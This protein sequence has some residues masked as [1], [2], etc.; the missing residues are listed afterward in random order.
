MVSAVPLR[1]Q[2]YESGVAQLYS[3]GNM[4]AKPKSRYY[5]RFA[6]ITA[7][8]LTAF[9]LLVDFASRFSDLF[10]DIYRF[11]V[12]IP[13]VATWI[14]EAEVYTRHPYPEG[15]TMETMLASV[16][17]VFLFMQWFLVGLAI[18]VVSGFFRLRSQ[19]VAT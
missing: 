10:G 4:N 17:W 16:L 9:T 12:T 7:V 14:L 8:V 5:F 1:G 6:L 15:G 19:N 2:R 13:W 18:G 11:L 3:F